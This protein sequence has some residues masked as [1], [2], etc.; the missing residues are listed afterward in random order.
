MTRRLSPLA[1]VFLTVF[2]GGLSVFTS[3]PAVYGAAE[4]QL[5]LLALGGIAL[6]ALAMMRR[7]SIG[8]QPPRILAPAKEPSR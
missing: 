2:I 8:G 3:Y 5:V 4:G 1:V 6:L 7:L